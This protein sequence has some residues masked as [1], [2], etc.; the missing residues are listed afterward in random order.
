MFC[1]ECGT[2][3][4]KGDAFCKECGSKLESVE[5]T[6]NKTKKEVSNAPK[7]PMAKSTKIIIGVVAVVVAALVAL[8][9]ILG[10]I[11]NPKNVAKEYIQAVV[12]KDGNKLYSYLNIEGDSTFVSKNVFNNYIKEKIK[13]DAVTNYKITEVEYSTG[14]LQATVRFTYTTKNSSSEKTGKV[15]LT[16]D[17][18]KK[19]LFFDNWKI[20]DSIDT[21]VVK[22]Y[23]L[24]VTKGSTLTYGGIKVDK[25]YLDSS[26]SSTEYD[27]Y[28]LPQVFGY[29]TVVK[30]VLPSGLEIEEKVTPSTYYSTH[31]VSFDEDTLTDAAKNKIIEVAKK[32]LNTIYTSAI[33][34][35]SFADI[36]SNFDVKGID[37]T[38]FEQSYNN[39]VIKLGNESNILT[40][41]TVTNA[42]IYDIDLDSNGYLEVEFKVNYDYAI[43]YTDYSNNEKTHSDSDYDYMTVTLT[44]KNGTYYL[45]NIN[46]LETYF[47]RY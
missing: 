6:T 2:K 37:L 21:A 13:D 1:G 36:K 4:K 3:N 26:K 33:A 41:F 23:T 7:K 40:S 31:T 32:D 35:K 10:N 15:T 46:E 25:K 47:S 30:A 29:E 22:D 12:N 20:N 11:T 39:F 28:V 16:K 19:Y 5:V 17:K 24:K 45:V 44:Y 42:S 9:I 43:K 8:F 38:K 27:V 34:K 18:S 14:K